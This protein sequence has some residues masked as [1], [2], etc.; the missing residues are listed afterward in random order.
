VILTFPKYPVP[1]GVYYQQAREPYSLASEL[2]K[3]AD[4]LATLFRAK[5]SWQQAWQISLLILSYQ[6]LL[7]RV[8]FGRSDGIPTFNRRLRKDASNCGA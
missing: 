3:S 7:E 1:L 2:K 8:N 6:R 5:A 4:D